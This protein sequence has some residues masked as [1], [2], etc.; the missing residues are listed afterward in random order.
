MFVISSFDRLYTLC[1]RE[2][3]C[4]DVKHTGLLQ[5]RRMYASYSGRSVHGMFRYV[6]AIYTNYCIDFKLYTNQNVLVA[7]I[8]R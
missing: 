1:E 4:Q 3:I 2:G 5:A 7:R 6:I 8:S